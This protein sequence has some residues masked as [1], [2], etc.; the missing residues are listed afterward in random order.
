[1]SHNVTSRFIGNSD[2]FQA[3]NFLQVLFGLEYAHAIPQLRKALEPSDA[4]V[5]FADPPSTEMEPA[6]CSKQDGG[7]GSTEA[8][9]RTNRETA[10]EA[11]AQIQITRDE[12]RGG[13]GQGDESAKEST[14]TWSNGSITGS[15]GEKF[16]SSE[17]EASIENESAPPGDAAEERVRF[18]L[19]AESSGASEEFRSGGLTWRLKRTEQMTDF[20]VAWV[21]GEGPALTDVMLTHNQ[22]EV[23]RYDPGEKRLLMDVADKSRFLRRR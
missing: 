20:V 7:S 13:S 4:D 9:S 22:C 6:S 23:V 21:G 17:P 19:G 15:M 5:R 16:S 2:D 8:P 11:P 10:Q 12:T 3:P 1:M 18:S 14:A